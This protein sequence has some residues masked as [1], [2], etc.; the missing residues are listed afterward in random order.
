MFIDKLIIWLSILQP[1]GL[2]SSATDF[3]NTGK[4]LIDS[5]KVV[6]VYQTWSFLFK[7]SF[8]EDPN[9]VLFC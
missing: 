5:D 9:F 2:N 3:G 1:P 7:W 6:N 8:K 4:A